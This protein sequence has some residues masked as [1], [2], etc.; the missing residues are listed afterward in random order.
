[1][2]IYYSDLLF[3]LKP[4]IDSLFKR[5]DSIIMVSSGGGSIETSLIG[6]LQVPSNAVSICKKPSILFKF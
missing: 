6:N 2:K 5:T 1:M 3:S 4:T